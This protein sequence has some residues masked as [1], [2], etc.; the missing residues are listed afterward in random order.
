MKTEKTELFKTKH[1]VY[2]F[3]KMHLKDLAEIYWFRNENEA[4]K[5]NKGRA[6]FYVRQYHEVQ[7]TIEQLDKLD[8]NY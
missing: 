7:D 2:M 3:A 5:G 4:G 1:D 8:Y 6:E